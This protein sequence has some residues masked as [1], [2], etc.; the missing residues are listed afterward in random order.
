M[1]ENRYEI[2]NRLASENPNSTGTVYDSI[3]QQ[4]Y[5]TG[6]GPTSQDVLIPAFLSAYGKRD[7][8]SI[9]LGYFPKIPLPNWRVTYDGLTKIKALAKVFRSATLSHAY[10]SIYT[11]GS[12]QSNL[13]FEEINGGASELYPSSNSFFPEY[14]ITQVTIQ[15]QFAPLFGLDLTWTNSLLTRF[16]Y[17]K[18][19]TI[20]FSMANKQ[21]TDMSTDEIVVGLGYKI[22]NVSFTISSLGGGGQKTQLNSDLNIKIDFSIRNNRTVLRRIDQNID[23]VSSGQ[24]VFSINS[25]ID[26]M[27]SRSV[28][29]RLFFDKIVNN[30][31]V[32]NQYRNSTTKGGISIRFSLAQ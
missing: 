27:L 9:Y 16:E 3:T 19:R 13:Y 25:A 6:Y 32:S 30:P 2:A 12:Y 28:T 11:I 14:D 18:T 31:F 4:F 26:Y 23:Q 29:L 8:G 7:P 17:R 22:K 24:R 21:L 20:T 5:P 1:K 15:E 10:R